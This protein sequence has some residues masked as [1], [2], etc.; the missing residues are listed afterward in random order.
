MSQGTRARRPGLQPRRSWGI[1][2]PFPREN[3][4]RATP[5][6]VLL[7]KPNPPWDCSSLGRSNWYLG[8]VW[9]G[10]PRL[11]LSARAGFSWWTGWTSAGSVL[12]QVCEGETTKTTT[13]TY[14]HHHCLVSPGKENK[15]YLSG[16]DSS[17]TTLTPTSKEVPKSVPKS[18][19][20]G[21]YWAQFGLTAERGGKGSPQVTSQSLGLFKPFLVLRGECRSP[22]AVHYTQ[23]THIICP[24]YFWQVYV[25]V[26]SHVVHHLLR[27]KTATFWG[28]SNPNSTPNNPKPTSPPYFNSSVAPMQ[29]L[30]SDGAQKQLRFIAWKLPKLQKISFLTSEKRS[31]LDMSSSESSSQSFQLLKSTLSQLSCSNSRSY[32]RTKNDLRTRNRLTRA[33]V[34]SGARKWPK[35]APEFEHDPNIH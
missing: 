12:Q 30:Q 35:I 13:T 15:Q 3:C 14:F 26:S 29:E 10:F 18:E 5:E 8:L 31:K 22:E 7:L 16:A 20:W 23:H 21:I 9:R 1:L 27:D 28:E 4:T 24:I 6:L 11:D 33:A 25:V 34:G 17:C 2:G 32:L 19:F